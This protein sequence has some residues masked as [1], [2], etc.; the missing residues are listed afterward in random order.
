[1]VIE[2]QLG[3]FSADKVQTAL[4]C[5]LPDDVNYF[6]QHSKLKLKHKETKDLVVDNPDSNKYNQNKHMG[7][8]LAIKLFPELE[9]VTFDEADALLH[10]KYVFNNMSTIQWL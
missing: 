6:I 7:R 2:L 3:Q 1:M 10:C 5:S 8:Q 9:K 4:V